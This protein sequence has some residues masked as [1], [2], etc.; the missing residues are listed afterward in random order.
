M[1]SY[2]SRA[3]FLPKQ[4]LFTTVPISQILLSVQLK[5]VKY[6]ISSSFFIRNNLKI[7][8]AM[9]YYYYANTLTTSKNEKVA[10]TK[11]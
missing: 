3:E 4:S 2:V 5:N 11:Y 9:H 1:F 8:H 6:S 7:W 10:T